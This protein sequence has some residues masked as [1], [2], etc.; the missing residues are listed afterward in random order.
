MKKGETWEDTVK[1]MEQYCDIMV[2]RHP[3]K[4]ILIKC[5]PLVQIPIINA[6]DGIGEHPTQALLDLYTIQQSHDTLQKSHDTI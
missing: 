3:E 4:G 5:I 6:G 1:T 2:I